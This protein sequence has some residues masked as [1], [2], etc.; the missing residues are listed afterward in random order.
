M[1]PREEK[2]NSLREQ[3]VEVRRETQELRRDAEEQSRDRELRLKVCGGAEAKRGNT[4][5][6]R[7]PYF[8]AVV[9]FA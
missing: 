5:L 3:I 8:L 1:D 6:T 2:L 4:S 9:M 7:S